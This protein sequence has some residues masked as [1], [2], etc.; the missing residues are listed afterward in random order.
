MLSK[1]ELLRS[2]L[3]KKVQIGPPEY[4]G[5]RISP[6]AEHSIEYFE[7]TKI[8]EDVFEAIRYNPHWVKLIVNQ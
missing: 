3:G 5:T 4:G 2:L 8:G 6:C 7:I 1:K